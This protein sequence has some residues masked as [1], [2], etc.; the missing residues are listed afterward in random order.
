MKH[1]NE[2]ILNLSGP[3]STLKQAD[4]PWKVSGTLILTRR[5]SL[6]LLELIEHP[7]IRNEKFKKTMADYSRKATHLPDGTTI[8]RD[9]EQDVVGG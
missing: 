2:K 5:E 4:L 9:S 8:I 3:R 1:S 7:V 6:R